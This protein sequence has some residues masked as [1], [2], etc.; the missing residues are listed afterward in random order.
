MGLKETPAFR[1][2]FDDLRVLPFSVLKKHGKIPRS[3]ENLTDTDDSNVKQVVFISYRWIN[4]CAYYDKNAKKLRPASPDDDERTT[5]N[6]IILAINTLLD[7]KGAFNSK[8]E[9]TENDIGV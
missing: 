1:N 5:Y 2:T 8:E 6:R 7:T 3:T 9:L 4:G